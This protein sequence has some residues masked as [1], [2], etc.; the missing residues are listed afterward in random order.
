M[1]KSISKTN[2]PRLT[3]EIPPALRRRIKVAG[4]ESWTADERL[5]NAVKSGLP[6]VRWIA[7]HL[8]PTNA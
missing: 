7:E 4:C 2:R 3:L 8:A 1:A 6:W 5:W